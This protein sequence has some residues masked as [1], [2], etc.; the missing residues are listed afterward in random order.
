M[1]FTDVSESDYYY[2]AVKWAVEKGII[3]GTSDTTFSPA[4]SCTRAQMV[5]FLWRAA[6]SPKANTTTCVFTDVDKDAYY[7]EALLWAVEN[8]ITNGTSATTF[9]PDAVCTR[10]QMATLLYRSAKGPAV[11]G[12]HSFTDAKAD[13][14]YND[15]VIWAAAEGITAGTSD[16]TFSPDA[17]CTRGQMVTF[18]YRY[19][20]K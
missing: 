1:V 20:A 14:Y 11:T 16:T 9:S 4:A 12:T 18:L 15:A 3:N 17:N 2:D 8:G 7:Y 5:T 13:A 10:G 19:L 6:G